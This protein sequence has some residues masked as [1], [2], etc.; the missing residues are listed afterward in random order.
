MRGIKKSRFIVLI[1]GLLI[2]PDRKQDVFKENAVFGGKNEKNTKPRR[3]P[4]ENDPIRQ[5]RLFIDLL[6]II[7][8]RIINPNCLIY[9]ID[10]QTY[11]KARLNQNDRY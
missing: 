7:G 6:L 9:H 1:L 4:M 8:V 11:N 5:T 10:Y 2:S 3:R